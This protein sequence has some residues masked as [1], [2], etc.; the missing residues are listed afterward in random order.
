MASIHKIKIKPGTVEIHTASSYGKQDTE[1][2]MK[3]YE[4]PHADLTNAFA[5]L[6]KVV[7]DVLQLPRDWMTGRITVTG[8]TFSESSSGVVGAV[9]TGQISLDTADAPFC[10][11]TPHLPFKQYSPTGKAKI[12]GE[13]NAERITK[14][15]EEAASFFA[16]KRAQTDLFEKKGAT[17]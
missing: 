1:T 4:A 16:G 13:R 17:A 9:L 15:R 2:I 14:V 7:Y 8:V 3:S 10:F 11:N 6:T 12:M 5:D